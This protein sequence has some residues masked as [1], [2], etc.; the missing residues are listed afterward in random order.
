MAWAAIAATTI[1]LGA[2]AI[3]GAG[4]KSQGN[5]LV[6]QQFPDY[7]IPSAITNAASQGLPSEQ[8]AQAMQNIQRQQSATISKA[9]DRR[10]GLAAIGMA[11][12]NSNDA[13]LN[14]DVANAKARQQ[15]QRTL[16]GYQ[17]KQWQL[18]TKGKYDRDYNYGMQLL[19]AGNQ[20]TASAIDSLGGLAGNIALRG[21]TSNF[22]GS[23][24]GSGYS[25]GANAYTMDRV[26]RFDPNVNG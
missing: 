23:G 7:N 11:Q 4:Q 26:P 10:S 24:M 12:Q 17:D 5:S 22:G 15:N 8:Y 20:N 19:G 9:Q 13:M 16:A 21:G 14:L 2:K 18:N 3:A 25:P 6:N 1:S